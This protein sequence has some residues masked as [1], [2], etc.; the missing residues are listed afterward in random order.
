M[1]KR[2]IFQ[3]K[4]EVILRK[5]NRKIQVE[6]NEWL[7]EVI[8]YSFQTTIENL[9]KY[10]KIISMNSY[11][12]DFCNAIMDAK[13]QHRDII[14]HIK[15]EK[16]PNNPKILEKSFR[17]GKRKKSKMGKKRGKIKKCLKTQKRKLM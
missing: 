5:L 6:L 3:E 9:R 15:I 1:V 10:E 11:H 4:E 8:M 7:V 12:I 14:D 2:T 17:M 13:G 16:I